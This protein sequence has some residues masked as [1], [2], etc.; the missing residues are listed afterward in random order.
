M[1][2]VSTTGVSLGTFSSR[3]C[4]GRYNNRLLPILSAL[5]AVGRTRMR[6]RVAGLLVPKIGSSR[7]VVESLY[8]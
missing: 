4:R 2:F 8:E 5:L 1:S 6:L 3:M 7:N